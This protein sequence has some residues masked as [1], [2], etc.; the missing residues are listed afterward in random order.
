MFNTNIT[1]DSSA[2]F[3]SEE[4]CKGWVE[5]LYLSS[6]PTM[7]EKNHRGVAYSVR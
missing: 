5:T 7:K 3:V 2:V 1:K 4:D 6:I